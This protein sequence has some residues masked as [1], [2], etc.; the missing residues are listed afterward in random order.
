MDEQIE[1]YTDGSCINSTNQGGWAYRILYSNEMICKSFGTIEHTTNNQMEMRAVLEA[2]R[3]YETLNDEYR[4]YTVIVRTDSAYVANAFNEKWIDKWKKNGWI[5]SNKT[6]VK[7]KELWEE[8]DIVI[9]RNGIHIERVQ[10]SDKNIKKVDL[11]ARESA[12]KNCSKT[13]I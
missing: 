6:P 4:A 13:Q 9:Y 10:R 1:I 3:R 12:K 5:S 8:L 11:K 7:N 2:L